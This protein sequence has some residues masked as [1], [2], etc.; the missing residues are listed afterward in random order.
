MTTINMD[1][2]AWVWE[3]FR[4]PYWPGRWVMDC[5]ECGECFLPGSTRDQAIATANLHN[6]IRHG[7]G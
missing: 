1:D 4:E 6:T 7:G 3:D 2:Y 5:P